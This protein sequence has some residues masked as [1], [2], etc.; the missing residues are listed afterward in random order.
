MKVARSLF[1][2]LAITALHAEPVPIRIVAANLTSGSQQAYSPDNGNH[3]N[4]EGAGARILKGLKPD[5]VLIQEFNTTIPSRQWVNETF[6][7]EFSF[8]VEAD[9]QIPNGIVSRFP[10]VESGEWKDPNLDNRDFAWAKIALPNG[11]TLWAISVH[12][13]SKKS[14]VR[15]KEA[16]EIIRAIRRKIPEKDYLVIGGDFNTRTAEEPCLRALV[17]IFPSQTNPPVDQAWNPATNANR[18]K[19]YDWVLPD[20]DLLRWAVS[21]KI[22]GQEFEHGLVFDTRM[23]WPLDQLPPIQVTDSAASQMQHMAVVKDFVLP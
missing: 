8:F 4:P 22:A 15:E 13:Y 7:E 21:V 20:A 9:A 17:P 12:L 5:I 10:I 1:L 19:P 16:K 23:F 11:D 14:D 2:L 18:N 3:S 6:G